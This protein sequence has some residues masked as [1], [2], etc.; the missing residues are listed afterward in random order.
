MSKLNPFEDTPPGSPKATKAANP[1]DEPE[2]PP[3]KPPLPRT[4]TNP[5]EDTDDEPPPIVSVPRPPKNEQSRPLIIPQPRQAHLSS[6]P[7]PRAFATPTIRY[8][9]PLFKNEVRPKPFQNVSGENASPTSPTP[10]LPPADPAVS[11]GFFRWLRRGSG[12]TPDTQS[13]DR[14]REDSAAAASIPT[15]ETHLTS[16][17]KKGHFCTKTWVVRVAISLFS[18]TSLGILINTDSHGVSLPKIHSPFTEQSI[19]LLYV[20]IVFSGLSGTFSFLLPLKAKFSRKQHVDNVST[21]SLESNLT[22]ADTGSKATTLRKWDMLVSFMMTGLYVVFF[23]FFFEKG[24]CH[25]TDKWCNFVNASFGFGV[26]ACSCW[27]WLFSLQLCRV[28]CSI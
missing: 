16:N 23:Y 15:E 14:P 17:K 9:Q 20:F 10:L 4:S 19:W 3:Y 27:I 22:L 13:S 21:A 1:F 26:L 7:P 8:D 25:S 28:C 2:P 18:F 11:G 6:L 24:A 12:P 5:F